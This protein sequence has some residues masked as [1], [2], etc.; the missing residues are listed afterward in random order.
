MVTWP[1]GRFQLG[2]AEKM[3]SFSWVERR[4]LFL[5]FFLTVFSGR[6]FLCLKWP[7]FRKSLLIY[8]PADW[9]ADWLGGAAAHADL[10]DINRHGHVVINGAMLTK[11]K[12]TNQKLLK[13]WNSEFVPETYFFGMCWFKIF[14]VSDA[15]DFH[16]HPLC[17]SLHVKIS[18]YMSETAMPG[19]KWN[20]LLIKKTL[21]CKKDHVS[22][23]NNSFYLFGSD[24][25]YRELWR[26]ISF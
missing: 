24:A 1:G 14:G 7:L 18:F 20:N 15:A 6:L 17:F 23:E 21:S 10:I 25:S 16:F 13:S 3:M 2:E 8:F 4:R 22:S 9:V 26:T 11:K 19:E 5:L 12:K